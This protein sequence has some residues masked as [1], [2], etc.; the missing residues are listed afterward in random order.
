MTRLTVWAKRPL[1]TFWGGE[2]QRN[3]ITASCDS[4]EHG[5]V[6]QR[7]EI[8]MMAAEGIYYDPTFVRYTE[9]YLDDFGCQ[10]YWRQIQNHPDL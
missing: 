4:I 3:T 6:L 9:P 1:A 2:G 5:F 8:D 10:E 7:D